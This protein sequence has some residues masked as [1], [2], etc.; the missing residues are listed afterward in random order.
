MQWY[1]NQGLAMFDMVLMD[2]NMPVLDGF[3]AARAI[4]T[5]ERERGVTRARTLTLTLTMSLTLT[6][7]LTLTPTRTLT[8]RDARARAHHGG[9]GLRLTQP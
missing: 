1:D 6:L 4:R 2:C 8:R 3:G 9:D 7:T 5:W